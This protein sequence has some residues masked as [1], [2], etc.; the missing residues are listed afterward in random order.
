[1]KNDLTGGFSLFFPPSQTTSIKCKK[2]TPSFINMLT[3][4][5]KRSQY[6]MLISKKSVLFHTCDRC[7]SSHC[8]HRLLESSKS[9]P[10]FHWSADQGFNSFEPSEVMQLPSDLQ[11]PVGTAAIRWSPGHSCQRCSGLCSSRVSA[12]SVVSS[13][14]RALAARPPPAASAGPRRGGPADVWAPRKEA[15]S[16]HCCDSLTGVWRSGLV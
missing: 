10:E 5:P 14:H 12:E 2:T 11:C 13:C 3:T 6:K 8:S 1:M 16:W 15:G 7:A 4:Q 9:E